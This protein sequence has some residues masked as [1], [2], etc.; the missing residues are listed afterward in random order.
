MTGYPADLLDPDLDLEAD[1]GVDTVKQ[2][3]V[4]AAVRAHWNLERDDTLQLREFPTLNHVAGWVRDQARRPRAVRHSG[5][6]R[7]TGTRCLGRDPPLPPPRRPAGDPI[8]DAV[9]G[10]VAEMT[11]YPADLLD[12]DLDLEADLGVDTVKQAEVFAAV[13]AHWN[14]ERDDTL[15]LREFPTLNHVAGWVRAK[16][17]TSAPTHR[18]RRRPPDAGTTDSAPA[19]APHTVIGDLDA[20]DALPRRVPVPSL[21]PAADQCLPTG[22]T[23][24]GRPR[25]RDARR[26]WR[27]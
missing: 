7:P 3:E 18:S 1:L 6:H 17:G 11:G 2:A 9:T 13:R 10:I 20:V 4:F 5:G 8:L 21:R 23:L 14:L 19:A 26:G 22:I 27:R 12:P 16:T 15:Q 25:R 24:A